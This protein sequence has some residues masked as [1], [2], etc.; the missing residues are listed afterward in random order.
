MFVSITHLYSSISALLHIQIALHPLESS[1][2]CAMADTVI[3]AVP[4]SLNSI[5][6]SSTEEEMILGGTSTVKEADAL[7]STDW[8]LSPDPLELEEELKPFLIVLSDVR[9]IRMCLIFFLSPDRGLLFLDDDGWIFLTL[10][11][12]SFEMAPASSRSPRVNPVS[13]LSLSCGCRAGLYVVVCARSPFIFRDGTRCADAKEG[14]D[15]FSLYRL[16]Q[17]DPLPTSPPLLLLLESIKSRHCSD[18]ALHMGASWHA[19]VY[20]GFSGSSSVESVLIVT[21][22]FSNRGTQAFGSLIR[23]EGIKTALL[24]GETPLF[25]VSNGESFRL[26]GL[27]SLSLEYLVTNISSSVNCLSWSFTDALS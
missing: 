6:P 9:V 16:L 12:T 14:L 18:M 10:V 25:G 11:T 22:R 8:I 17:L 13:E 5:P 15:P 21:R 19:L 7:L 24:N 4:P 27:V 1:T 26:P 20:C 3:T 2:C 23:G